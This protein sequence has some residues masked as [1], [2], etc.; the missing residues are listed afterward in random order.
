M[1]PNVKVVICA[2]MFAVILFLMTG[3]GVVTPDTFT[4]IGEMPEISH[5]MMQRM[6]AEEPAQAQVLMSTLARRNEELDRLYERAAALE[7]APPVAP[8]KTE[9]EPVAS[10]VS[11]AADVNAIAATVA[12]T[13]ALQPSGAMG[14]A[15]GSVEIR[16]AIA[17]REVAPTEPAPVAAAISTPEP[18]P[19]A[20]PIAAP[21]PVPA[22]AAGPDP[23]PV[24]VAAL[25]PAEDAKP[26]AS[27][28]SPHQIK[29][30]HLRPTAKATPA[31]KRTFHRRRFAPVQA[32]NFGLFGQPTLQSR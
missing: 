32:N 29:T 10:A 15:S 20:A 6:I 12:A 23:A 17:G 2:V 8:A 22:A 1:L 30:P 5:P 14:T 9:P 26:P 11:E 21:E 7:I 13:P 19:I 4:R 31:R 27:S 3:A 18:A 25:P 24:Q 16:P 28:P